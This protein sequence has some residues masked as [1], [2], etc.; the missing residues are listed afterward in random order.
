MYFVSSA[1][2]LIFLGAPPPRGLDIPRSATEDTF[3]MAIT[4]NKRRDELVDQL[5]D[6]GEGPNAEVARMLDHSSV[7]YWW[8]SRMAKDWTSSPRTVTAIA[9]KIAPGRWR[10]GKLAFGDMFLHETTQ[11]GAP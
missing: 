5:V 8:G 2:C 6:L 3:K 11:S 7:S 9:G 1:A 10:K 4:L